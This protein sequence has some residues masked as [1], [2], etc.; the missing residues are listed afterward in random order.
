MI[1]S[2]IRQ[3]LISLSFTLVT[4]E[5]LALVLKV[6]KKHLLIVMLNNF[7]TNPL[8]QITTISLGI[9]LGNSIAIK[10]LWALEI[11]VVLIE[12]AI[13]RKT[14]VKSLLNPFL[15][16][17]VLNGGSFFL[18]KIFERVLGVIL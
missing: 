3:I 11:L 7:L 4:E 16:S 15:L 1:Y 2:I 18:G 6:K 9:Y 17:L 14:K 13:Y 8:V 12:G 5:L 10:V